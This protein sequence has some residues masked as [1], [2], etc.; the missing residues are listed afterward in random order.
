YLII[1]SA[2]GLGLIIHSGGVQPLALEFSEND[3]DKVLVKRKGKAITGGYL[4]AQLGGA[5]M[6]QVLDEV[7]PK[8]GKHIMQ[9]LAAAL[10]ALAPAPQATPKA[11]AR[12]VVLIPTGRLALLP[13]HAAQYEQ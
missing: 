6:Q 7:L 12:L 2:G 9:P 8:L 3:L 11:V 13:L 1:T 5:P 10:D 4:P